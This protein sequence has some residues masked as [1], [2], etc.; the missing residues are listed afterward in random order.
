M[1]PFEFD[2]DSYLLQHPVKP[3]IKEMTQSATD[4]KLYFIEKLG[5]S[6]RLM[7]RCLG[8]AL[9]AYVVTMLT[10]ILSRLPLHLWAWMR[11][12]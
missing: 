6:E 2:E 11:G 8:E 9:S 5:L 4:H 1:H 7:E 3:I 12:W 10:F